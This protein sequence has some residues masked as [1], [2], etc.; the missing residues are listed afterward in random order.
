MPRPD[1]SETRIAQILDAFETCLV[2]HGL[3]GTSLEK[4]AGVAGVQRS[5]IRHYI[6]NRDQLLL[7]YARR[8]VERYETVIEEMIAA[9]PTRN[10]SAKLVDYLFM[11]DSN[12]NAQAELAMD[13]LI[14]ASD[15]NSECRKILAQFVENFVN[16][17][18]V[19]MAT[20]HPQAKKS[21]RW[22]VANGLVAICF[23]AE[24]LMP[25]HLS[26]R[27]EKSWKRCAKQLIDSLSKS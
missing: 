7:A 6:G 9:L 17:L 24:A 21:D 15:H 12:S 1:L 8:S 13:V 5:I 2:Q 11:P 14:A 26:K 19:E 20:I 10:R 23:S 4:V 3:D 16:L 18:T 25:L 22:S 27:H